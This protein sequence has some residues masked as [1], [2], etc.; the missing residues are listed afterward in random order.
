[1]PSFL[2]EGSE[3]YQL[4]K[5]CTGLL[6]RNVQRPLQ[7]SQT[8]LIH[9]QAKLPLFTSKTSNGELRCRRGFEKEDSCFGSR[10]STRKWRNDAERWA[11][12]NNLRCSLQA[13]IQLFT[14]LTHKMG[15]ISNASWFLTLSTQHNGKC[16]WLQNENRLIK[17][18]RLLV[19]GNCTQRGRAVHT[20][21]D[22]AGLSQTYGVQLKLTW[23]LCA[24]FMCFLRRR[25]CLT[26]HRHG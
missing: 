11:Q 18:L 25:V 5:E 8:K 26:G 19:L 16:K 20:S 17:P 12:A 1:M 24:P 10:R 2:I 14:G 15:C 13:V 23:E 4:S 9:S 21:A 3:I 6:L 7:K 22:A